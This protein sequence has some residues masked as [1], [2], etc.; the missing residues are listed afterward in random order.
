MRFSAQLLLPLLLFSSCSFLDN[1]D[2]AA[3]RRKAQALIDSMAA[4]DR[5]TRTTDLTNRRDE[6]VLHMPYKTDA[7][8]MLVYT[9]LFWNSKAKQEQTGLSATVDDVARI[10]LVSRLRCDTFTPVAGDGLHNRIDLIIGDSLFSTRKT[11][12]SIQ[13]IEDKDLE[14]INFPA[15]EA[16]I[17]ASAIARHLKDSIVV[18]TFFN[19]REYHVYTLSYDD[20][21]AMYDCVELSKV[22][23]RK[24]VV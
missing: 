3:D 1:S 18:H 4:V 5:F 7:S 15:T 6:L 10:H 13:V 17:I 19:D 8:G 21:K 12:G 20:K 24:S 22:L 14:V 9:P 11:G 23:D 16:T 2:P